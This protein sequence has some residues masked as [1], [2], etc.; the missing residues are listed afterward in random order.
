MNKMLLLFAA[1]LLCMTSQAQELGYKVVELHQAPGQF[2]NELPEADEETTQEEVCQNAQMSLAQNS[3]V[4][5][6]TYGGY[7]TIKFDGPLAAR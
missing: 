3:L 5:L 1:L 4:S 6:G 7:I 2:V